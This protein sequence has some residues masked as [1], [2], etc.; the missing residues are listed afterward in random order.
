[1]MTTYVVLWWRTTEA[2]PGWR[3]SRGPTIR[4]TYPTMDEAEARYRRL[5]CEPNT[6]GVLIT[7]TRWSA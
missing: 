5:R 1:M 7:T 4:E 3:V 2:A 6:A